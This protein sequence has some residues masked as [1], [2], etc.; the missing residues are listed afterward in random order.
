VPSNES[1]L[2]HRVTINEVLRD[3]TVLEP[4]LPPVLISLTAIAFIALVVSTLICRWDVA[5]S[6]MIGLIAAGVIWWQGSLIKR[7]IAF[8]TYIEFDKE[9]NSPD[10]IKVRKKV[11]DPQDRWDDSSLEGALEFFEKLASFRL[12]D[13]LDA[14]LIFDS[15]L[16]WYAARLLAVFP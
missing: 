6:L 8:S 12:K 10:M 13:V 2:K 9:W 4:F 5:A 1:K 3:P 7:Q 11:R 16:G 14:G 15:T